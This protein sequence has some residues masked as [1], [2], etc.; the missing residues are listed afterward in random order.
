MKKIVLSTV[1]SLV[2]FYA[3]ANVNDENDSITAMVNVKES[4]DVK[5]ISPT[6]LDDVYQDNG[7]NSNW[8]ISLQGGT[9]VFFGNPIG[10]GDFF[11]KVKPLMNVSVG[12]WINPYIG[13]RINFEGLKLESSTG[14]SNAYQNLHVDFLYSISARSHRNVSLPKWNCMAYVGTGIIR[15]NDTDRMPFALSLGL[16]AQR[17]ITDRINISGELGTSLTFRDF[18]GVGDNYKFG[19][20]L[21]H[22]SIGMTYTIGGVGWNRVIDAKPYMVQ[23]DQLFG[24]IRNLKYENDELNKKLYSSEIA[25]KEMKKILEIEGLINKYNIKPESDKII[26]YPKNNYSGLN[27]LRERLRNR[28]WTDPQ[29]YES[30]NTIEVLYQADSIAHSTEDYIRL[31][32]EGKTCI[33]AP[34]FFFF[35]INTDKLTDMSQEINAKEIAAVM[36]KYG[37]K[38]RII[39]AADSLTGNDEINKRLSEKRAEYIKKVLTSFKVPDSAITIVARGG[40]DDYSTAEE[41]RNTCVKLYIK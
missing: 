25:L 39:G 16:I 14:H 19:D 29:N 2:A 5:P 31:L 28:N 21:L 22:A 4:H 8:F 10:C 17:R 18:D 32:S 3:F 41:N 24:N 38:A 40:I 30:D 9:S 33:G 37:L 26:A 13:A 7:W 20:K 35:R 34:V 15:N 6:Y 23:N 12:K 1:F 36:N 27:S 11:D